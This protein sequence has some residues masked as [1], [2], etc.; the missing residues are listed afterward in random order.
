MLRFC[1][2]IV[3]Q[4][5]NSRGNKM[6]KAMHASLRC[7]LS[8]E[9]KKPTAKSKEKFALIADLGSIIVPDDYVHGTRLTSFKEKYQNEKVKSFYY[10][11]DLIIDANFSNSSRI[12][13][14][15][16]KLWVRVFE[17]VVSGLQPILACLPGLIEAL[18][19]AGAD[20]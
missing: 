7:G 12:L 17:Q 8:A 4:V 14:P 2:D 19:L 16:D 3:Q 11:N 10:Y 6:A 9:P 20:N 18:V 15:G 13:K 1:G 5:I